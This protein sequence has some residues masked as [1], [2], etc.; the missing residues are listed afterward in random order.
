MRGARSPRGSRSTT[1]SGRTARLAIRRPQRSRGSSLLALAP[2]RYAGL[3]QSKESPN[4]VSMS[5]DSPCGFRGQV[6]ANIYAIVKVRVFELAISRKHLL[7][8]GV[9]FILWGSLILLGCKLMEIMRRFDEW[10][11]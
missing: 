11:A 3:R 6:T 5:Y 8:Y 4:R 10:A 9:P 2:S 7:L 1:R